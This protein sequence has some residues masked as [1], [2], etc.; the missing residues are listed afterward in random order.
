[1][2]FVFKVMIILMMIVGTATA[3][4]LLK[5]HHEEKPAG[6]VDEGVPVAPVLGHQDH[7]QQAGQFQPDVAH[8]AALDDGLVLTQAL[9][10][11]KVMTSLKL[12]RM[13]R[14]TTTRRRI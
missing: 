5:I 13:L 14:S 8:T 4:F 7:P 1:M 10:L 3:I 11:I 6:V 2:C 9:H 12:A